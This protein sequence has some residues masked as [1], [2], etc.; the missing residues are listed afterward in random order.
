MHLN[1]IR[2][3]WLLTAIAAMVALTPSMSQAAVLTATFTEQQVGGASADTGPDLFSLAVSGGPDIS[4]NQITFTL[5]S[6]FP[7]VFD[8][9]SGDPGIDPGY[10]VTPIV[11]NGLTA[12][13]FNVVDGGTTLT[14][15]FTGTGFG[16]AGDLLE[17]T[18]DVDDENAIVRGYDISFPDEISNMRGTQVSVD[19]SFEGKDLTTDFVLDAA[20]GDLINFQFTN[21]SFN[22]AQADWY[23]GVTGTA[24]LVPEPASVAVWSLLC[25]CMVGVRRRRRR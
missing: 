15:D 9:T 6:V 3:L 19:Y 11:T 21:G 10:A 1:N 8:T 4:I 16:D 24:Q 13:V 23:S 22:N 25:L 5:P 17:F 20:A 7:I 2:S 12:P 14:L 18:A